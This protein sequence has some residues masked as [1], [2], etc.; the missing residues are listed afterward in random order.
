[1]QTSYK[2]WTYN[3]HGELFRPSGRKVNVKAVTSNGY[4]NVNVGGL[5]VLY[6]R[7]MFRLHKGYWADYVDHIDQDK[8]N[9]RPDNLRDV[10]ITTNNHNTGL[11]SNN[12]SGV[13]GVTWDKSRNKW[14]A[15]FQENGKVL[16][17]R[18]VDKADAI[19]QRKQWEQDYARRN[20]IES[21]EVQRD[22]R[23]DVESHS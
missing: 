21:Y 3:E 7:L 23:E 12:T 10:S 4:R 6:H 1:M 8:L 9:N 22:I 13:K 15:H 17:R 16:T 18:F 5:T 2:G 11:Q 19:T 20:L 14:K